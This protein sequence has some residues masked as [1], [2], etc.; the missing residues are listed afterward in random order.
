MGLLD[1]LQPANP[2]SEQRRWSDVPIGM[3]LG[4]LGNQLM[5]L[6]QGRAADPAG[7]AILARAGDQTLEERKAA[8]RKKQL[9]AYGA[10]HPNPQVR[11]MI[12]SG[13]YDEDMAAAILKQDMDFDRF[14][15]E[16]DYEQQLTKQ[17]MQETLGLLGIRPPA[18]GGAPATMPSGSAELSGGGQSAGYQPQGPDELNLALTM[19]AEGKGPGEITQA[20]VDL[21]LKKQTEARMQQGEQRQQ[22]AEIDRRGD[23]IGDEF[24]KTMEPLSVAIKA[25]DFVE[26]LPRNPETGLPQASG[27]QQIQVLYSFIKA[28]DPESVVREAEVSLSQEAVA[29]LDRLS[30]WKTKLAEGGVLPP[31]AVADI[32]N[33]ISVIGNVAKDSAQRK[34]VQ[35]FDR[36][37]R[38]GVS[39]MGAY[40]AGTSADIP[41]GGMGPVVPKKYTT[42]RGS[43]EEQYGD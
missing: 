7:L 16:K 29:M 2:D 39:D 1:F 31:E 24:T 42:T 41:Q 23:D 35:A 37:A 27:A 12:A 8:K 43:F 5:A 4:V 18:G 34:R 40:I 13:M 3:R 33:A 14:K 38:R 21:R 30:F 11:E 10:K 36:G 26:S 19:A 17:K 28:L 15:R 9:M 25:A 20:L 6:S 22:G 32:S